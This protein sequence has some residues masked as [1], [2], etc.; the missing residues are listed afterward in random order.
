MLPKALLWKDWNHPRTCGENKSWLYLKTLFPGSP[1]HLRGKLA[2][3]KPKPFE[4]R[5]TPAPAGK[6]IALNHFQNGNRDHPRTC[7]ENLLFWEP[8]C[9]HTGS[10]PHLRGKRT[11]HR[12][13]QAQQGIT[14]APAGKTSFRLW[15]MVKL[16]DHPRTCGENVLTSIFL[17]MT[18]GSPPHLRGKREQT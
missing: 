18:T 4:C 14:P 1:P 12:A 15:K 5:I 17:H 2:K 7:G 6:T 3:T 8:S 11:A 10:P 16:W 13:L 9:L